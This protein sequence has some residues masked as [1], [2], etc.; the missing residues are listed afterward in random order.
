M[1]MNCCSIPRSMKFHG[2]IGGMELQLALVRVNHQEVLN[3]S[4]YGTLVEVK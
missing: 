1:N 2:T 4:L 3:S